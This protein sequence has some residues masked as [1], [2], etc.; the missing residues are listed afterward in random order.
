VHE[1]EERRNRARVERQF[2]ED[3][4]DDEYEEDEDDGGGGTMSVTLSMYEI[5]GQKLFDL[6]NKKEEL[7]ALEDERGVLQ[8]VGLTQH[9]CSSL[10]EF[11]QTSNIG[12]TARTTA[13][14]GAND[15]SSRSH[16][17]S[18]KEEEEEVVVVVV[19]VVVEA[20]GVGGAC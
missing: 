1:E 5:K 2:L 11:V 16:C 20:L 19:V 9:E 8:L 15:T 4:Q 14:T 12:R 6:L 10:E 7:R 17:A 13:S 3:G 18:K